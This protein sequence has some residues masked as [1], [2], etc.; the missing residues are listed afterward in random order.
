[1]GEKHGEPFKSIQRVHYDMLDFSGVLHNLQYLLLFERARSDFWVNHG[2]WPGAEGFEDWPFVAV[3]HEVDYRAPIR[4]PTNVAI[5]CSVPEFGDKSLTFTQKMLMDDGQIAA[6][7]LTI[8][9]RVDAN[10]G[11]A[12]A[13]SDRTRNLLTKIQSDA[14]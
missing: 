10:T 3:R 14:N 12:I 7:N 11:E 6:E 13:W 9:V 4:H 1:M 5:W 8:L 2:M